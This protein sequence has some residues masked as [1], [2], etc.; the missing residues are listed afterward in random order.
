[1]SYHHALSHGQVHSKIWLLDKLE[2]Y[3]LD[4]NNKCHGKIHILGS[5]INMLPFMM[6][7]RKPHAYSAIRCYDLDKQA[8]IFGKMVTD[9]WNFDPPI[10]KT[11][12]TDANMVVFSKHTPNIVINCSPEHMRDSQ[13]FDHIPTDS[14]V[15]IQ[16]SDVTIREEPWLITNPHPT[17]TDFRAK[18][19]LRETYFC[20]TLRI[21]YT[22]S[23]YNRFMIIGKK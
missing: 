23:G 6:L 19:P 18:Y 4:A 3:I 8:T 22:E 14:V 21:Q 13:W 2:P 9:A 7:V 12:Y 11:I 15:C 10:V 5:W 16:S 1:M 17:I 20:D